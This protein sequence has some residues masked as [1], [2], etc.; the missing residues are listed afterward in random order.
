VDRSLREPAAEK[1]LLRSLERRQRR[2]M[3]RFSFFIHRFNDPVMA[4]LF[5]QPSNRLQIEQGMISM[6]AGDLF[7]APRVLLRLQ[8]FKLVY[9]L[10]CLRDWRR[11]RAERSYRLAQARA[12]FTGGNTPLDRA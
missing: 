7:D 1:A 4:R 6:L 9:A 3:R 5:R 12:R 10:G 11:W 2:G 8:L